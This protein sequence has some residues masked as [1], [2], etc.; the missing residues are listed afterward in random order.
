MI[1]CHLWVILDAVT[2]TLLKGVS[3]FRGEWIII[4]KSYL[5]KC[6]FNVIFAVNHL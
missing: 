4:F 2:A 6:G 1:W 5:P 3:A